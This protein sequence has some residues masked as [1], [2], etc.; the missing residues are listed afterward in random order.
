MSRS[1]EEQALYHLYQDNIESF[2]LYKQVR[3][4]RRI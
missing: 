4:E 2:D 1:E 3:K